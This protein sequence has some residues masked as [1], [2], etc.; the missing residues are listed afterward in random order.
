MKLSDKASGRAMS[1]QSF[2]FSGRVSSERE[3]RVLPFEYLG[4]L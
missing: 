1:F 4:I 3:D 2:Q